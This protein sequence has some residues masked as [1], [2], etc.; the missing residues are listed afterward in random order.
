MGEELN[1]LIEAAKKVETPSALTTFRAR[2]G[3]SR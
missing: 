3:P 1:K 2:L